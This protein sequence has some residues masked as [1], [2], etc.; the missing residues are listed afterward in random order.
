MAEDKNNNLLKTP[1]K[2]APLSIKDGLNN[3]I[4]AFLKSALENNLFDAVLIPVKVPSN[5]SYAWVLTEDTEFLD[6]ANALSPVMPVQG[7][8]ALSSITKHGMAQ[9]KI[10]AV[11]RP[12][13]IRASIELK[14]LDQINTENITLISMDCSGVLPLKD[15]LNDAEKGEDIFANTVKND[16]IAP[17]RP[18]CQTCV[19][20]SL[21]APDVHI[22]TIGMD[23]NT[24]MVIAAS[25]KGEKLIE[26]IGMEAT[27]DTTKW[28]KEVDK[29]KKERVAAR[30]SANANIKDESGGIEKFPAAFSKCISCHNCMRVCPVCYCRR[31]YFESEVIDML[32][33]QY[34]EKAKQKGSIKLSPNVLLFHLG[35]MSHMT[36]SCVSCGC[37]EDACPVG[38]PVAEIFSA[39]AADSQALFE[40]IP[41]INAD[42][43][44]PM[45]I[46]IKEKELSEVENICRD[47]LA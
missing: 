19:H 26:E 36:T 31:C 32:P 39:V 29:L 2:G 11:M 18:V 15:Y 13:E 6:R 46:F 43:P 44:L 10:A 27:E 24:A 20:F 1:E 22:A 23:G 5:D 40:Y 9:R 37:C 3:A 34:L 4:I 28:K 7:A 42:E 14:K 25:E 12:C 38:I 35:R 16:D 30:E 45:R 33:E 41:G 47:P 17:M 21:T 8:K